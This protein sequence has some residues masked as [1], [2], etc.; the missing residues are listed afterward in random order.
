MYA[1]ELVCGH[2]LDPVRFHLFGV[3]VYVALVDTAIAVSTK[4]T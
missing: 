3:S 4:A 2:M 1:R